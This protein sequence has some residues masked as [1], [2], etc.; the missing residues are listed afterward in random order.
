MLLSSETEVLLVSL[1]VFFSR[2][3]SVNSGL[4][5]LHCHR[6]ASLE[7]DHIMRTAIVNR[8]SILYIQSSE[9]KIQIHWH[10]HNFL[11]DVWKHA[12]CCVCVHLE[13]PTLLS[14]SSSAD[15][16]LQGFRSA[17]CSLVSFLPL[18]AVSTSHHYRDQG[19]SVALANHQ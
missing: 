17:A 13:A 4:F 16:V 3:T 7:S 19:V 9:W 12:V 18:L 1:H 10:V 6:F 11:R 2:Q 5:Y 14:A 8:D 15:A